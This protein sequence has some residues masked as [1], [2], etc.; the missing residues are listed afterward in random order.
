MLSDLRC[1]IMISSPD[2]NLSLDGNGPFGELEGNNIPQ[3]EKITHKL[4]Q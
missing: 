1:L 3:P 2:F 4:I